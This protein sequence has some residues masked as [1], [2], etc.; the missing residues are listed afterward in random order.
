L[1]LA[2]LPPSLPACVVG[3][4]CVDII[5]GNDLRNAVNTNC[6]WLR[7]S[8]S[9]QMEND[10]EKLK[11]CW[12]LVFAHWLYN[13]LWCVYLIIMTANKQLSLFLCTTFHSRCVIISIGTS[14]SSFL[15]AS[16]M[17]FSNSYI[18]CNL[19][20]TKVTDWSRVSLMLAHC[21]LKM[22][23]FHSWISFV[24]RR[25]AEYDSTCRTAEAEM[26]Y[27]TICHLSFRPRSF[28]PGH[29][30]PWS[31]RTWSFRILVISSLGHFVP[32][33]YI[34]HFHSTCVKKYLNCVCCH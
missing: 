22:G 28:R 24:A 2:T 34:I 5:M 10:E 12:H 8:I 19:T 29:F 26:G 31:F 18:K 23:D 11:S 1:Y 16:E 33:F 7:S 6:C 21:I 13:L 15:A 30:V 3:G 25:I 20:V 14:Y 27:P 9:T 32:S 17:K 4:E